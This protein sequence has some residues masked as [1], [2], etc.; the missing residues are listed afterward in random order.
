MAETL[1]GPEAAGG[2]T[3]LPLRVPDNSHTITATIPDRMT[4]VA[5]SFTNRERDCGIRAI[6]I[7]RLLDH[8]NSPMLV[9]TLVHCISVRG[10]G[11]R[12]N[13]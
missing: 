10:G 7:Y 11:V 1:C 13:E 2:R 6:F 4:D 8:G 12:F 9:E 3:S 5:M